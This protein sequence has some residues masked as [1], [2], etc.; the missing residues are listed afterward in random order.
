MSK[1]YR[2]GK[3]FLSFFTKGSGLYLAVGATG[4][5]ILSLFALFLMPEEEAVET[6]QPLDTQQTAQMPD[7]DE[8][9]AISSSDLSATDSQDVSSD[10]VSED[11]P[12]DEPMED[13]A[14]IVPVSGTVG[15]EFSLTVPVFSETMNDW[16]IHQGIDYH[17]DHAVDVAAAADGIV[18]QIYYDELMGR[19]VE[20]LHADGTISIYQSLSDEIPVL[21]GQEVLQGDV[22]GKTGNTADCESTEGIHLH[23]ALL[24]DGAYL[25]PAERFN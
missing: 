3:G 10:A 4:L 1:F 16:R 25:N 21:L 19:T 15:K 14:M 23:F 13:V 17:T 12:S 24:R 7:T 8:L 18:D 22:I 20:I 5:V 11:I 2:N 6:L 9:S